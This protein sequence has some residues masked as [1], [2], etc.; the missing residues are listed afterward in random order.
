METMSAAE[1]AEALTAGQLASGQP[2]SSLA[3]GGTSGRP[4]RS[5]NDRCGNESMGKPMSRPRAGR[6]PANGPY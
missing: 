4:D 3:M 6:R 1:N 2:P 5:P